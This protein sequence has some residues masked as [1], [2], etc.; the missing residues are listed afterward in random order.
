M[1]SG[2][3]NTPGAEEKKQEGEYREGRI[4]GHSMV[5][6]TQGEEMSSPTAWTQESQAQYFNTNN[7]EKVIKISSRRPH[8]AFHTSLEDSVGMLVFV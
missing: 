5:P 4:E 8:W 1:T 2:E 3:T 6:G 7:K